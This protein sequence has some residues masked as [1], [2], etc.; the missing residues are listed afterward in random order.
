MLKGNFCIQLGSEMLRFSSQRNGWTATLFEFGTIGLLDELLAAG[1]ASASGILSEGSFDDLKEQVVDRVLK[2]QGLGNEGERGALRNLLPRKA[3]EFKPSSYKYKALEGLLPSLRSKYLENWRKELS[4]TAYHSWPAV[5][6]GDRA[7]QPLEVAS[8]LTAF[9][10]EEGVSLDYIVKWLDYRV[11]HTS[12]SIHLADLIAQME[13]LY[14]RGKKTVEVL[15]ILE[16]T[17]TP[18]LWSSLNLLSAT[19][20][21]E[22]IST[23]SFELP[24]EQTLRLHGGLVVSIEEWDIPGSLVRVGSLLSRI[25]R[26]AQMNGWKAPQFSNSAWIKGIPKEQ[27]I[28][29]E[30]PMG[31]ILVGTQVDSR[32]LLL[33]SSEN[34]LEVALEFVEAAATAGGASAAG[35]LWAALESLFAAPG[36]PIRLEVVSRAADIGLLAF[37]RFDLKNALAITM[38][39][40]KLSPIV[41]KMKAEPVGERLASFEAFVRA[42]DFSSIKQLRVRTHLEHTAALIT[43]EGLAAR[44]AQLQKSLRSLY[45]HRNF[46]LHG[47][48]NDAPLLNSVLRGG[49]PLVCAIVEKYGRSGQAAGEDPYT[50]ATSSYMKIERYL[51][52]SNQALGAI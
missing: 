6:K 26:R 21:R 34:R 4:V 14:R 40:E 45:R 9:L 42:G 44:R 13:E 22:W 19:S 48:V 27:R 11:T 3:T 24:S 23:N 5:K 47:G 1:R 7:A 52:D 49:Y 17:V 28:P 38:E 8:R 16:Q 12:K 30:N 32:A 2:D 39:H 43:V 20:V 18:V 46:V 15:V 29:R 31:G 36:D 51:W 25:R 33:P 41:Q 10:L 35:M 37:V 50:F